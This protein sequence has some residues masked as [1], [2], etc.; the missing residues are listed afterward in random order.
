MKV[1]KILAIINI[2]LCGI[3]FYLYNYIKSNRLKLLAQGS[4]L[5]D[6]YEFNNFILLINSMAMTILFILGI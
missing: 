4:N 6:I 1:Y 3:S 2:V 5:K